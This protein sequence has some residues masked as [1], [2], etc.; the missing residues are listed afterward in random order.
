MAQTLKLE[1]VTPEGTI[2]SQDVEMVTLPGVEG[3]MGI[4]P[5]HAALMTSVVPG[6][7]TYRL[8]GGEHFF[9]IGPGFA[10]VTGDHVAILTDMAI[11]ADDMDDAKA[12]EARKAAEARLRERLGDA[13]A[14]MVNAA[15][16][17]SLAQ[18]RGR[19]SFKR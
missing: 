5:Q 4:Y 12:E 3:E 14:A 16:T 18:V 11:S 1:I 17:K 8:G 9:A 19:K 15:I 2:C 10:E 6:Q 13:E 7:L